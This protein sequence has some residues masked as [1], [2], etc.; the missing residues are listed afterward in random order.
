[1]F[2]AKTIMK[3][4]VITVK[5]DTGIYEAIRIMVENNITGLPVVNDDMSLAGVISEKDVLKL[6][7]NIED[8]PG[9]VENFM[10]KGVVTFGQDDSLI[11]ITECFIKNYFRRVPIMANGKLVGIISRKDIISYILKLRHKDKQPV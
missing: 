6:L 10:T 4:E 2:K 3:T 8:Q 7:Y 9:E 5:K 1:M 11:D